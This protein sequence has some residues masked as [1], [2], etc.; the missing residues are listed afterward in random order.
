M[1]TSTERAV[2][3]SL[4]LA[5]PCALRAQSWDQQM[6]P[7]RFARVSARV[8]RRF[9]HDWDELHD[10]RFEWSYCV[11]G[12][13]LGLTQD[14]DTVFVVDSVI[15]VKG[16][17]ASAHGIKGFDCADEQPIAH[18]HPSGDCSP[19]RADIATAVARPKSPFELV[20]CGPEQTLSYVGAMYRAAIIGYA[21]N[22][23]SS[24]KEKP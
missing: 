18:A 19:S 17:H 23:T 22:S 15:A 3:L 6:L 7:L 11:A 4:L 20:I 12:W 5:M 10:G 21:P 9:R 2:W 8:R 13:T 24:T 16:A 1:R 14:G